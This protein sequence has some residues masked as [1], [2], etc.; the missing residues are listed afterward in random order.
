MTND[1]HNIFYRQFSADEFCK[2]IFSSCLH[3]SLKGLKQP[4]LSERCNYLFNIADILPV[5]IAFFV[6]D[7]LLMFISFGFAGKLITDY[8]L[9]RSV[10]MFVREV[11]RATNCIID[12][13][14]LVDFVVVRS[15]PLPSAAASYYLQ[16]LCR[17]ALPGGHS[18]VC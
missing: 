12:R 2:F 4:Y 14:V 8:L 17:F 11:L 18:Y 10:L 5:D 7:V 1:D 15:T 6:A 16:A 13:N 9:K 3:R